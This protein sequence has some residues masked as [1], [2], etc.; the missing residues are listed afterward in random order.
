MKNIYFTRFMPT[1]E[2]GGG[3]RRM[4]QM[5]ETLKRLKSECH[6]VSTQRKDF[7]S[8]EALKR[9]EKNIPMDNKYRLWSEKRRKSVYRLS[10]ISREWTRSIREIPRLELAVLDDPP[11]FPPTAF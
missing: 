5:W 2:R 4:I 10:E 1:C 7:L 3:S 6:V 9:I 8:M 11:P